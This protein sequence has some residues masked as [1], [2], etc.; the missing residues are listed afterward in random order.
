M[1]YSLNERDEFDDLDEL[2]LA[3]S[4]SAKIK[5]DGQA[6][7]DASVA[8]IGLMMDEVYKNDVKIYKHIGG[9]WVAEVQYHGINFISVAGKIKPKIWLEWQTE[10]GLDDDEEEEEDDDDDS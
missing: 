2:V 3:A 10:N 5:Q 4:Q 1:G 6:K 9:N 8:M 7:Y